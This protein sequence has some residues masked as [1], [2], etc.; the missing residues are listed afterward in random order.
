MTSLGC[1]I[2]SKGVALKK[3]VMEDE[4]EFDNNDNGSFYH[5][6]K[7]SSIKFLHFLRCK[8][9]DS[10]SLLTLF[11]NKSIEKIVMERCLLWTP[12]SLC[13]P[14]DCFEGAKCI[15]FKNCAF[16]GYALLH[17]VALF[18]EIESVE[19]VTIE[20]SM[21][22]KNAQ[23]YLRSVTET[24]RLVFWDCEGAGDA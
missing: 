15:T 13:N 3:L 1:Q 16:W 5:E 19:Y 7:G 11:G 9:S 23:N 24:I 6:I 18:D 21:M 8:I 20:G 2:A 10:E 17:W 4:R 12:D 14:D 22:S